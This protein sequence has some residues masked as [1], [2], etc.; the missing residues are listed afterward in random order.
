MSHRM[1]DAVVE[2]EARRVEIGDY[3][4]RA[5]FAPGAYAVLDDGARTLTDAWLYFHVQALEGD[6]QV[7][8]G[9]DVVATRAAWVFHAFPVGDCHDCP[10]STGFEA[11]AEEFGLDAVLRPMRREIVAEAEAR[12]VELRRVDARVRELRMLA[13]VERKVELADSDLNLC[14]SLTHVSIMQ[15]FAL[16]GFFRLD[17][18]A[19]AVRVAAHHEGK[20]RGEGSLLGSITDGGTA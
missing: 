2:F 7:E 9:L 10:Q 12:L 14:L 16:V 19:T 11:E 1:M 20:R 18:I 5:W 4:S 13:L 8:D 17:D 15:T 6:E 3:L